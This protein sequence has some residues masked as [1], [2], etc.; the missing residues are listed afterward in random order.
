VI[1]MIHEFDK[2]KADAKRRLRNKTLGI[3]GVVK[4]FKV[5]RMIVKEWQEEVEAED[6]EEQ[7]RK[8]NPEQAVIVRKFMLPKSLSDKIDAYTNESKSC[9]T[10]ED[11]VIKILFE[12]FHPHDYNLNNQAEFEF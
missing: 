12:Y 10:R 2:V 5:P 8:S 11:S 9:K 7:I 3:S 4:A 1:I 6:Y